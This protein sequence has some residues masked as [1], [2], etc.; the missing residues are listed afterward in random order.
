M[1]LT[2]DLPVS[3]YPFSASPATPAQEPRVSTP[4][5][6]QEKEIRGPHM[7]G[8]ASRL[9][10]QKTPEMLLAEQKIE[11]EKLKL[12]NKQTQRDLQDIEK[13]IRNSKSESRVKLMLDYGQLE[14]MKIG[15]D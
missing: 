13:L 9:T 12:E 11:E 2:R 5:Q 15:Q 6:S 8:D 7:L 10:K 4:A 3:D 14:L 1:Q